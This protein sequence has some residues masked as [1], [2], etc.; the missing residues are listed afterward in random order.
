MN[1]ELIRE[2]KNAI[3]SIVLTLVLFIPLLVLA[4]AQGPEEV[5]LIAS[6]GFVV[7][8]LFERV[9]LY[10]TIARLHKLGAKS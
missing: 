7:G 3:R 8:Y 6:L 10:R 4:Y 5:L 9:R 2:R 1:Q